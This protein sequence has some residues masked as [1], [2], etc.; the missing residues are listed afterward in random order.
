MIKVDFTTD[1]HT[2][3]QNAAAPL[4]VAPHKQD[5]AAPQP[6]TPGQHHDVTGDDSPRG[7]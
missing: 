2:H 7:G 5:V 6:P 3:D 1:Q 4:P